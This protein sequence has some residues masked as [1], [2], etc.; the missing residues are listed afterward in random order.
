MPVPKRAVRFP[1]LGSPWSVLK[2][3]FRG[4]RHVEL[5]VAGW[6]REGGIPG[7]GTGRVVYRVGTIPVLPSRV[8]PAADWYCQDPT[9][10]S[11]RYLRPPRHSRAPSG[12]PSAHLGSS[13]SDTRLWSN[14][15]RFSHKYPKVS[16]YSRVS[17]KSV[18]E[19]WHTPYFKKPL[20]SHD[21]EFLG[22]P[23]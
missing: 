20:K 15:A 10:A 4:V 6:V 13:H 16:Q 7:L 21:L 8:L 18:H 2:R 1:P 14:R 19:A 9:S 11:T 5:V 17:P 23:I 3:L 22:F 12:H